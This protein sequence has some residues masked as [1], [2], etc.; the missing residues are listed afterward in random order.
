MLSHLYWWQIVYTYCLYLFDDKFHICTIYGIWINEFILQNIL[1]KYGRSTLKQPAY[2]NRISY[3]SLAIIFVWRFKHIHHTGAMLPYFCSKSYKNVNQLSV[4]NCHLTSRD[5]SELI[6]ITVASSRTLRGFESRLRIL[7][8][9]VC[10]NT[11][12]LSVWIAL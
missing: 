10:S 3:H 9:G 6:A 8:F 11:S 5:S 4:M 7:K 1:I 12:D 2:A